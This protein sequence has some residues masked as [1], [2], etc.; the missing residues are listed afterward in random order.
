MDHTGPCA[1]TDV[2]DCYCFEPLPV[3]CTPKIILKTPVLTQA[4][5]SF[6][7]LTPLSDHDQNL[8]E[9]LCCDKCH[10]LCSNEG[11]YFKEDPNAILNHFTFSLIGKPDSDLPCG[12]TFDHVCPECISTG[13]GDHG[14]LTSDGLT[15]EAPTDPV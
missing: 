10:Y 13:N 12:D 7:C 2:P 15:S 6:L 1:C 8:G 5:Y 3:G 4:P 11:C 9:E 14:H